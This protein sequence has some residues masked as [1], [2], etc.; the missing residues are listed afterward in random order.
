MTLLELSAAATQGGNIPTAY[1]DEAYVA[2]LRELGDSI[3]AGQN[4]STAVGHVLHD[5]AKL[6]EERTLQRDQARTG[7]LV[8]RDAVAGVVEAIKAFLPRN[9]D[10][11]NATWADGTVVP[12]DTTLGELRALSAAL[13]AIKGG[14]DADG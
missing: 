7:Q 6:I 9:I 14:E 5:A 1:E 3:I 4:V 10:L 11:S 12:L 2:G 8:E 13:T